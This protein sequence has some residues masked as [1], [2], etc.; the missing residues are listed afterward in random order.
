M[1]NNY[2]EYITDK[3]S[4][5]E[6]SN[7]WKTKISDTEHHDLIND[8]DVGF[9]KVITTTFFKTLLEHSKCKCGCKAKHIS[10]GIE[11]YRK[12]LIKNAL[13][14]IQPDISV[15]ITMKELLIGYFKEH[16]YCNF[17]PI[18]QKCYKICINRFP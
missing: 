10:Y 11:I 1:K 8:L 9:F 18:C 12:D 14:K 6:K 15:P 5:I 17:S 3:L 16:K 4:D 2:C 7:R 13:R